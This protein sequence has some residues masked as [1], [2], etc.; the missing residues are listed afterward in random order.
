MGST[1]LNVQALPLLVRHNLHSGVGAAGIIL[2]ICAAIEIPAMLG[3]GVLSKRVP[4]HRLVL[5]GP[6]FGMTYFALAS[7]VGQVWQLGV[8]QVFNAC[9]IAVIQGLAISYVQEFLPHHPGRAST[10]YSNTF[11]CGAILASPLLGIGA[12]FGYRFSFVAAIGLA[13]GGLVLLTLGRPS[14]R[15]CASGVGARG[16]EVAAGSRP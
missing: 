11:P 13:A 6:L 10:L 16:S 12:K 1:S 7:V 4:L 3:F 14:R 9:Y 8:A 2:G 5:L 15:T